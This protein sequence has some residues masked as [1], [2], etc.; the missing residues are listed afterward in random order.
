M[1]GVNWRTKCTFE[2]VIAR[3]LFKTAFLPHLLLHMLHLGNPK[4]RNWRPY[5]YIRWFSVKIHLKDVHAKCRTAFFLKS[6]SSKCTPVNFCYCISCLVIYVGLTYFFSSSG[7]RHNCSNGMYSRPS[8]RA[9]SLPYS[10]AKSCMGAF[11]LRL[12]LGM[13]SLIDLKL[14]S[15]FLSILSSAHLSSQVGI[16]RSEQAFINISINRSAR[17]W[18][19]VSICFIGNWQ[20]NALFYQRNESIRYICSFCFW[21]SNSF[22]WLLKF[23]LYSWCTDSAS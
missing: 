4:C 6:C 12:A 1:H 19:A 17:N 15:T 5:C 2:V 22:T 14:R 18:H 21:Q 11:T 10:S 8:L 23:F 20:R 7:L 13:A 3:H 16:I 9:V